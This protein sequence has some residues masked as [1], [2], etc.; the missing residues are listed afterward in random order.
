MDGCEGNDVSQPCA[1]DVNG[2]KDVQ[3]KSVNH[4]RN[5]GCDP[6][7]F[8]RPAEDWL[9]ERDDSVIPCEEVPIEWIT[10]DP[11]NIC[12]NVTDKKLFPVH[13]QATNDEPRSC[14]A[15][16]ARSVCDSHRNDMC[17]ISK[18]DGHLDQI[19]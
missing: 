12:D 3:E 4:R 7:G 14:R 16:F 2:L 6:S 17:A 5:P 1:D 11:D 15:V 19:Q 8:Q 9:T 13:G 18:R 10:E